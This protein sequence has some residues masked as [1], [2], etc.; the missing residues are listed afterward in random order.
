[1][2]QWLDSTGISWH[3][4]CGGI[5]TD[6]GSDVFF[7]SGATF[8]KDQRWVYQEWLGLGNLVKNA[9]VLPGSML[10]GNFSWEYLLEPRI[11]DQL[12]MSA[13]KSSVDV[14]AFWSIGWWFLLTSTT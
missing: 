4:L 7:P 10:I 3:G 8:R 6:N 14:M 9:S 2:K 12:S 1:M 11:S 5:L 13:Q